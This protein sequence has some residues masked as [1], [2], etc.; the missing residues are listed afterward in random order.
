[1]KVTLEDCIPLHFFRKIPTKM[2]VEIDELVMELFDK[3][4]IDVMIEK[5]YLLETLYLMTPD[6]AD[7]LTKY[8]DDYEYHTIFALYSHIQPVLKEIFEGRKYYERFP[9]YLI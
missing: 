5:N 4:M 3:E 9:E 8:A 7:H 6:M 2:K 1:M